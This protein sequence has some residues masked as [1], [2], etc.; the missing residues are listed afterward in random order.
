MTDNSKVTVE[1]TIEA[2]VDAVFDVL[3]NPERHPA[4]DGSGFVR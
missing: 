3:S 4:L 2:P 1:R